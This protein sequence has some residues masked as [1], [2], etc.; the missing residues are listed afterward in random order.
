MNAKFIKIVESGDIKARIEK[1]SNYLDKKYY[2]VLIKDERLIV[3]ANDSNYSVGDEI[4][5]EINPEKIGVYD[6]NFG[7]KLI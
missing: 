5:I 3:L 2:E 4:Y 1:I 6:E 7:V